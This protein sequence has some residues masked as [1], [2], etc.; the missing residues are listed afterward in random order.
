[1]E[2]FHPDSPVRTDSLSWLTCPPPTSPSPPI[3]ASHFR[4]SS[5][6]LPPEDVSREASRPNRRINFTPVELRV[7][8]KLSRDHT[9]MLST[10][11]RD[12]LRLL[13]RFALPA[14]S[15]LMFGGL[16]LDDD[17]EVVANSDC[18]VLR[19]ADAQR[20][21]QDADELRLVAGLP[22]DLHS[23]GM[24]VDSNGRVLLSGGI[25]MNRMLDTV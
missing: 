6:L 7:I 23:M 2:S 13:E 15:L 4:P 1:M 14:P 11:P 17:G 18:R 24:C 20:A 16:S 3:L 22:E 9:S 25:S 21:W 10:V 8:D 19:L 5:Q 12:I